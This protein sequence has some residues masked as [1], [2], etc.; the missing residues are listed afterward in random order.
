MKNNLFLLVILCL[1]MHH[2]QAQIKPFKPTEVDILIKSL[3]E[4]NA[5]GISAMA[6]QEKQDIYSLQRGLVK[7]DDQQVLSKDTR[8][9]MASV[10][11]HITAAAI[12]KLLA[13]QKIAMGQHVGTWLPSLPKQAQGITVAQLL[14]HSSG[15]LD[16][17]NLIPTDQ[18]Q[19]LLDADILPFLA[20]TDSLY[21]PSGSRFRYSNTGYCLLAL[22]VE[23][24]AGQSYASFVQEQLFAPLGLAEARVYQEHVNIA[25]RAYGYHPSGDTYLFADQSLTSATKGDGGVYFSTNDFHTWAYPLMQQLKDPAYKK[26]FLENAMPVNETVQYSMGLFSYQD[27]QGNLYCFHSGESTGFNNI[28]YLDVSRNL[29]VSVFANRDDECLTEPF[30]AILL[31]VDKQQVKRSKINQPLFK[32]LSAVYEGQQ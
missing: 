28:I 24:V 14:N 15:I 13:D 4:A 31:R 10:S 18:T 26:M 19:Q 23:Q 17:E 7:L 2:T 29:A 1:T 21:F 22:I 12:Y 6:T 9:R 8:F 5:P 20:T 25:D 16:Y 32:W 27:Q 3:V 30:E 11:K